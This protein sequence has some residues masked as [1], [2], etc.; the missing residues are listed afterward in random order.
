MME[1][2]K[3]FGFYETLMDAL[4]SHLLLMGS[5]GRYRAWTTRLLHPSPFFGK[6]DKEARTE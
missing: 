2:Q 5:R 3:I 4:L 6:I 1:D